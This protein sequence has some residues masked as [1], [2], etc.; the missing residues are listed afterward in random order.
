MVDEN[1]TFEQAPAEKVT[2]FFGT[3]IKEALEAP[4]PGPEDIDDLAETPLAYE[5]ICEPLLKELYGVVQKRAHFE[6]YEKQ[7]KEETR[8]LLGKDLGMIQRGAYGVDAKEVAGRTVTEWERAIIMIKFWAKD[9]FGDPKA[10]ESAAKEIDRIVASCK[11]PGSPTVK[12]TP[13]RV[14][15]EPVDGI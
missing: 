10:G 7:L 3:P 9:Q 14:G 1:F 12:L 4:L 13:Y 5:Q 6:K 11:T 2:A 8:K 15:A